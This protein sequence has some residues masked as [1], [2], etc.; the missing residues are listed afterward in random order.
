MVQWLSLHAS[1]AE[2]AG[3]IPG[4]GTEIS[5]AVQ[6]GQMKQNAQ[7]NLRVNKTPIKIPM[8]YVTELEQII[9]LRSWHP[10]P[11]WVC[12]KLHQLCPTL[13]NPMDCRPP[14]S[15]VHEIL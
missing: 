15:P 10:V 2:D 14:G 7:S 13:C 6:R 3:L 4:W 5:H 8:V 12:A 9:K 11:S 1:N